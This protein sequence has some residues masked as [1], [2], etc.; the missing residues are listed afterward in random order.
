MNTISMR[1]WQKTKIGTLGKIV[2]GKTPST[3]VKSYFGE[4]YPFITIP[5]LRGQRYVSSTQRGLS[6]DGAEQIKAQLLPKGAVMLSCIATVGEVGIAKK[7]SFTNQQ[8]NSL[9]CDPEKV[10]PEF[11]YYQFLG[12]RPYLAGYGGGGSF[13]IPNF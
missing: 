12:L 5:D 10:F 11:I 6:D 7:P 8:I 13:Y 3:K 9:I 1:G 2:T 4:K